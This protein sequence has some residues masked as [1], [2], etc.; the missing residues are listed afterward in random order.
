MTDG[1]LLRQRVAAWSVPFVAAVLVSLLLSLL[2]A[3]AGAMYGVYLAALPVAM[4]AWLKPRLT[5]A[6]GA[7]MG[8]AAGGTIPLRS[9]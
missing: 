5:A 1:L 3:T 7:V 8:A 4:A 6:G 9:L 2:A